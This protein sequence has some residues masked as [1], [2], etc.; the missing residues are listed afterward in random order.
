[1]L[2]AGALAGNRV[3]RRKLLIVTHVWM[4]L[5]AGLLGVFTTASGMMTPWGLLGFLFAIG[6]GYAMM[7]PALLAVLPELVEPRR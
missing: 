4:M 1:M 5:A 7:S 3:D 2:F 6:A